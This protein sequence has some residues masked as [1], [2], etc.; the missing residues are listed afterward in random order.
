MKRHLQLIF[1]FALM[2]FFAIGANA[3]GFSWDFSKKTYSEA[4]ETKVV[5]ESDYATLVSEQTD[6]DGT[7]ANNYLGGDDNNRTSSR[8]Y[9][10]CVVTITPADG[11]EISSVVFECTTN[12][13]AKALKDSAWENAEAGQADAIVT[14]TPTD[15]TK[16]FSVTM[17]AT[18]GLK[19]VTVN[20]NQ[21]GGVKAPD[22][23][24]VTGT[25]EEDQ[26]VTI[27]AEEGLTVYY[28]LDDGEF[29]AYSAPFTVSKTTKVSAYAT[30]AAGNQS[31]TTVSTITIGAYIYQAEFK[32][33]PGD[34]TTNNVTMS[35]SMTY[36]WTNNSYGWVASAFV[37]GAAQEAESWL[38]SPAFKT[39]AGSEIILSFMHALNKG[40]KDA[41]GLY[42][43]EDKTNWTEVTVPNWPAGT[44]WDFIS[45]GDIDL[46]SYAGK[47]IYLGFKY[48]S[49]TSNAPSWEIQ[50]LQLKGKG[51]YNQ[52]EAPEYT[53]IAA[54]KA[55][56]TV[57]K[58]SSVLKLKGVTVVYVNGSSTYITD[59]TDGFLLYG[60]SLGLKQGENV[61][62]TVTGQLYLYNGLPE[63]S[64]SKVDET[65]VNSENNVVEPMV[66][67]VA[68]LLANPMK[69][70]NL[71]VK[72]EGVGI[73][74]E[75]WTER[76]VTLI[77]DGEECGMRDNWNIATDMTFK[78]DM[79]YNITG[80][81]SIHNTDVQLY[82]RTTDDIELITSQAKPAS[83][84]KDGETEVTSL[85]FSS[86]DDA[87]S[88][89]FSTDTDGAVTFSSSDESVAT[90][91]EQG[92]ITLVGAGLCTIKA[93]TAETAAFQASTA[94]LD[95]KVLILQ[96]DGTKENPYTIADVQLLYDDTTPSEP[97]WITGYIV[98]CVNGALNKPAWT[99]DS[100]NIVKTN[101]IISDN[102]DAE[103]VD[104]CIP[105]ELA[106]GEIRD[107]NNLADHP[108]NLGQQMKALGVITKYFS[109]CGIK[110]VTELIIGEEQQPETKK[111]DVNEDTK[112]DISDIVAV[113]NQ[114]AGTATYKNADVNGDDKVDISDIVAIINIIAG[115]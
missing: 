14:V 99:A 70:S 12:A 46:S 114:I 103:S 95:I 64:V 98:G 56:A 71:L 25:Y 29:Q 36:V 115:Q 16:P 27:T 61:D 87:V 75:A 32:N 100:E 66:V 89:V 104:E 92:K 79:D 62:I 69:Y 13:Y 26:T 52:A 51:S 81:V 18:S 90:V 59:G 43:S 22:I 28:S 68:E 9:K 30:D 7:K 91:D 93:E 101:F 60:S 97:V 39:E 35:S 45:S 57:D 84:W 73:E 24:P 110:S 108:E 31:P 10:G 67:E 76:N 88:A 80:F 1:S 55:A 63:L 58:I 47:T 78:T 96:G 94:S 15:G 49:T 113:I 38:I 102:K 72:L 86:I 50:E 21:A 111:G 44:N 107:N 105:M 85:E 74:E 48:T 20:Y 65:T 109:V 34:F 11:Y 3:E 42:V 83:A 77:Q 37:G 5:W 41:C 33:N 112:V 19:T 40:S 54:A 82:P 6:K 2:A 23:S 4:S 17:S 106:K 53:T 8:F